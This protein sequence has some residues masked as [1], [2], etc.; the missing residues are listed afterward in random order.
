[1]KSTILELSELF[2]ITK[3]QIL[4]SNK[5]RLVIPQYQREYIWSDDK[6]QTLISDIYARDKFL[7]NLILD[8]KEDRYEIVDGQQRITTCFIA[9]ICIYNYYHG[10]TYEQQALKSFITPVQRY[11]VEN[12]SLGTYLQ[13]EDGKIKLSIDPQNDIYN[14]TATFQQAFDTVGSF[15]EDL[16]NTQQVSDFKDKLLKSKVMIL[17]ND[18]DPITRSIEQIFLDINEKAQLLQPEDIFKGYCFKNTHTDFHNVLRE[19]WIDLKKCASGFSSLGFDNLSEYLYVY[20]L[21][22]YNKDITQNL[23]IERKHILDGKTTDQTLGLID[24]MIGFGNS[25]LNFISNINTSSYRFSDI[26]PDSAHFSNTNDHK[27]LKFMCHE[28]LLLNGANYQKI[29][30]MC[31][32]SCLTTLPAVQANMTHSYLR[33]IITQLYIYSG[34]FALSGMRKSKANM[35]TSVWDKLTADPFD[36]S[37]VNSA[38]KALR[39][40]K[41]DS[42]QIPINIHKFD[43]LSNLYTVLDCYDKTSGFLS[44]CYS[45]DNGYN[46]EHFVAPDNRSHQITWCT[47]DASTQI[48]LDRELIHNLK[49]RTINYLILDQDL[50]GNMGARDIET[51]IQQIETWFSVRNKEI[52]RHISIIISHIKQMDAYNA[53]ISLKGTNSTTE[54]IK[55]T[56]E[57]FLLAYISDENQANILTKLT[58]AFKSIF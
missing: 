15:I 22:T 57:E 27:Y 23:Y 14:Q 30:L 48:E 38:A 56:Y 39:K 5:R 32:V 58:A 36:V 8:E 53:L 31:F 6:I 19:K 52:P 49:G 9:L 54:Q 33:R 51:K 2:T 11:C 25:I 43:M 4:D 26:C 24:S 35:D 7:G 1:M 28:Q 16:E 46:L 18:N 55:Q 37:A 44:D 41:T 12:D 47:T 42:M 13:E 21:A 45:S 40:A 3:S 50:N 10:Q 29:P 20:L 17:I 34:L